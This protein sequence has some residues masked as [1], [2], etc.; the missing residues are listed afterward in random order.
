MKELR[1]SKEPVLRTQH[2]RLT[3]IYLEKQR[4]PNWPLAFLLLLTDEEVNK[5]CS[6]AIRGCLFGAVVRRGQ[7]LAQ[8]QFPLLQFW[9]R[10]PM[11]TYYHVSDY[12][13]H[14]TWPLILSLCSHLS[15]PEIEL[16]SSRN[17]SK[18][19]MVPN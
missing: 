18:G 10:S 16:L 19:S 14:M 17:F 4:V 6:D 13:G 9:I 15:F 2:R 7:A 12:Q 11:E 5:M 1:K 3:T 8:A